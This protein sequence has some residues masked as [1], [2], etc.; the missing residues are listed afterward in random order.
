MFVALSLT[1]IL[2]CCQLYEARGYASAKN[3]APSLRH[4]SLPNGGKNSGTPPYAQMDL[5]LSGG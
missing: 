3:R 1:N 5:P 2:S 4:R